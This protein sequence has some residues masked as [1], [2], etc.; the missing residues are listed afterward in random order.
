MDVV[1]ARLCFYYFYALLLAQFAQYYSCL[2]Y[3]SQDADTGVLALYDATTK[4][5]SSIEDFMDTLDCLFALQRIRYDA[6]REVLCY[7]A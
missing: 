2:L 4:H 6:E 5:F 7:V 1:W 3:T